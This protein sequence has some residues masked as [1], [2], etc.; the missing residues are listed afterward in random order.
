MA[1][2]DISEPKT[3]CCI[4]SI[5]EWPVSTR[6]MR[7]WQGKGCLSLYN[8]YELIVPWFVI[9]IERMCESVASVWL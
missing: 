3:M 7:R 2:F 5:V 8:R 6:R 4:L 1:L 9:A